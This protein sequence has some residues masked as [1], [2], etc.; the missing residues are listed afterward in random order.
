[1]WTAAETRKDFH[2]FQFL[3]E[4]VVGSDGTGAIGHYECSHIKTHRAKLPF[5]TKSPGKLKTVMSGNEI[6]R[7]VNN[8]AKEADI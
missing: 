8:G 4:C 7:N 3:G 1:M 6:E 5:R 2:T